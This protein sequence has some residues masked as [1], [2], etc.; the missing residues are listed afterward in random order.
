MKTIRMISR[1]GTK[2]KTFVHFTENLNPEDTFSGVYFK[3]LTTEERTFFCGLKTF[4]HWQQM[5]LYFTMD[6]YVVPEYSIAILLKS[7]LCHET[8]ED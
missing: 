3:Q 1:G 6:V 8:R 5:L 7:V 2:K 4:L